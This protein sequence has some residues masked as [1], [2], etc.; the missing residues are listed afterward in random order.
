MTGKYSSA[1]NTRTAPI[2]P[3]DRSCNCE[4]DS[5]DKPVDRPGE[6]TDPES[7]EL[8]I[9]VLRIRTSGGMITH[10]QKVAVIEVLA[11]WMNGLG[12]EEFGEGLFK[13][14]DALTNDLERE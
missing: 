11:Q 5:R 9:L 1:G 8:T 14:R 12:G 3:K 6:D 10:T 13:L 2:G 4:R 7:A